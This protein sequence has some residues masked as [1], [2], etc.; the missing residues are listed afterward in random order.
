MD[1][2]PR[3]QVNDLPSP[4]KVGEHR[5]WEIYTA[6]P[7]TFSIRKGGQTVGPF[8]SQQEAE[9]AIDLEEGKARPSQR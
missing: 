8:R 4:R 5:G 2:A 1:R 6:A 7:E 9:A 3:P